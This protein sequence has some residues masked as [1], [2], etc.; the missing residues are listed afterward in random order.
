MYNR[1][2]E[3]T[4]SDSKTIRLQLVLQCS[5]QS[6]LICTITDTCT[7]IYIYIYIYIYICFIVQ[8][9]TVWGNRFE[10]CDHR[11]F[12]CAC[13]EQFILFLG[14]YLC[15]VDCPSPGE[16][17]WSWVNTVHLFTIPAMARLLKAHEIQ[18][19]IKSEP[20]LLEGCEFIC[21]RC[22][23][24]IYKSRRQTCLGRDRKSWMMVWR[25]RWYL[26]L[27]SHY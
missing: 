8:V 5:R 24:A 15:W 6:G 9:T 14:R 16:A 2:W 27:H 13:L 18:H 7:H 1:G 3:E 22:T 12:C 19:D 11:R 25:L 21:D 20:A 10:W 17:S 4:G 23:L 26:T